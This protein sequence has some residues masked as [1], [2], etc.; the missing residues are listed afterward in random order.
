MPSPEELYGVSLLGM[1]NS[2][3]VAGACSGAEWASC[4]AFIG[5]LRYFSSW[6]AHLLA[7]PYHLGMLIVSDWL[8]LLWH[9]R[10]TSFVEEGILRSYI[11]T[12]WS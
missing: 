7:H 8:P 2:T 1:F 11:I 9:S 10:Q 12:T 5:R 3:P 6:A 4:Q